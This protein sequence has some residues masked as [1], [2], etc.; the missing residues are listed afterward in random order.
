M[1]EIILAE[2]LNKSFNGLKAVD[3]ISI[4]VGRGEIFGFLGPNGAGKTTT[5]RMLTGLLRADSGKILIDKLDI[6]RDPI[7]AKMKMGIIP[8]TSNIY[9]D[10]TARENIILAGRF[11]GIPKGRLNEKADMLLKKVGLHDKRNIPVRS[12]SKGMKQKVSLAC[13]L[14]NDAEVYFLDEPT[15]GLDVHS[16]KLIRE[17]IGDIKKTG[18]TVFLTS[19]DIEEANL[20]CERIAIINRGRLAA[21]DTPENLKRT[22]EESRAV[23][24]AFERLLGEEKISE[25]RHA[26]RTEKMGD[27][28]RIYTAAPDLLVKELSALAERENL[29]FVSLEILGASLEDVFIRLTGKTDGN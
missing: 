16:R 18:A 23:E 10:M 2:N 29:S 14:V 9:V 26:E 15:S 11:Y 21:V 22:F 20:I 3:N 17:I 19:H 6:S 12:F 1:E 24:V 5:V 27:K 7:K 13:A 8:E 28:L 4:S 25:L